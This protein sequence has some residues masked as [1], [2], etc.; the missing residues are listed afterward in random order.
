[1]NNEGHSLNMIIEVI[2]KN[3]QSARF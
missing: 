3:E 1:M 2:I